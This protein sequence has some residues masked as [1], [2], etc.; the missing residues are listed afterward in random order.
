MLLVF[1][2]SVKLCRFV[3]FAV[4]EPSKNRLPAPTLAS[5]VFTPAPN[6]KI[7]VLALVR[8]SVPSTS[9]DQQLTL[10][11][12]SAALTLLANAKTVIMRMI[13]SLFI[14]DH[15]HIK[16]DWLLLSV[17]SMAKN[18]IS[19]TANMGHEFQTLSSF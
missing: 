16:S 8:E 11:S 2:P 15:P 4:L 5:E 18:N 1:V 14:A 3:L 6:W 12:P 9:P 10:P 19:T 7:R 13:T 17:A